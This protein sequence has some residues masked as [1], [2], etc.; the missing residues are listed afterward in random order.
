MDKFDWNIEKSLKYASINSA[1]V[2]TN[3]GAQE[4]FLTFDEIETK[5]KNAKDFE[6]KIYKAEECV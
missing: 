5:L 6:V 4:G 2:C 3:F 1:S